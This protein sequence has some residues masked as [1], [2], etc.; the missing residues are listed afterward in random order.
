MTYSVN[1][2]CTAMKNFILWFWLTYFINI[3]PWMDAHIRNLEYTNWD[4]YHN[5][6]LL[7]K[8]YVC[9]NQKNWKKKNNINF[10]V[11][12]KIVKYN[13]MTIYMYTTLHTAQTCVLNSRQFLR[14]V[15][16]NKCIVILL[17]ICLFQISDNRREIR[18][19][20]NLV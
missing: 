20:I 9:K 5:I 18:K 13:T 7:I 12:S 8:I 1:D 16:H 15:I 4:F 6:N 14:Q 19:S 10:M 3:L 17:N 11:R 2:K